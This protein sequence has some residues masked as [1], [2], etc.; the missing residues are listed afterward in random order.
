MADY[1]ISHTDDENDSSS[2][3]S[4]DERRNHG[5]MFV[6]AAAYLLM[7]SV[8]KTPCRTSALTG[9]QYIAELLSGHP[10]RCY[11]QLR[12]KPHVFLLLCERLK[13]LN[14]LQDTRN[15]SA[16]EQ[17]AIGLNVLCQACTQRIVA[18][19]FQHST[20]TVHKCVKTTVR[21]LV[22]LGNE[23]IRPQNRGHVQPEILRNKK[24]YPYFE[25]LL[26]T[27]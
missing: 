3:S 7:E 19:R 22:A 2:S 27:I 21:A 13:G 14:V 26:I 10:S 15:V 11:E 18:E 24:Y 17:L 9:N 16:E 8:E 12:V 23:I 25:V 6:L 5:H 1:T 4:D 20:A